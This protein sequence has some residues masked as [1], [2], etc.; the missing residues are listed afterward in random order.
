[1]SLT[2]TG[3]KIEGGGQYE[4]PPPD[5]LRWELGPDL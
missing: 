2:V 1:M 4:T 5:L 3:A